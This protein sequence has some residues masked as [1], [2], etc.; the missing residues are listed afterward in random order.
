MYIFHSTV[1]V[2]PGR[3][4]A[5]EAF[6]DGADPVERADGYICRQLLKDRTRQ[7][8]Y[9]Y[10]SAWASFELLS[11]WRAG[12]ISQAKARAM[13]GA[14]LFAG[15]LDLVECGLIYDHSIADNHPLRGIGA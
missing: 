14:D 2:K 15:A 11:A 1:R 7:G 8:V 9:F 6:Y 5:F 12:E 3:E 4:A 10:I 13:N